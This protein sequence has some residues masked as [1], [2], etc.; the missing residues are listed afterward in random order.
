MDV[1]QCSIVLAPF[2]FFNLLFDWKKDTYRKLNPKLI[3]TAID[4]I[5][6]RFE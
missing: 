1:D 3:Q 2:W 6:I 5:K 4:F